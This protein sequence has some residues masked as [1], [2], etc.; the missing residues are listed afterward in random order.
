MD[1]EKRQPEP[2]NGHGD[3]ELTLTFQGTWRRRQGKLE[4]SAKSPDGLGH[5]S[6]PKQ[7]SLLHRAAGPDE[8][9]TLAT[10]TQRFCFSP[11][12]TFHLHKLSIATLY[13]D[14]QVRLGLAWWNNGRKASLGIL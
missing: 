1:T 8:P 12:T 13:F 4:A 5:P 9:I 7:P 10:F 3:V 2:G 14:T 6:H 11:A